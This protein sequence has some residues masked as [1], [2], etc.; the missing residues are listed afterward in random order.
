QCFGGHAGVTKNEMLQALERNAAAADAAPDWP[1]A[2]WQALRDGG[3]LAWNIPEAFGGQGRHGRD[4][5]DAYQ[6]LA[7][8]CLTTCFILSQRDGAVRRICDHGSE[9]LR[10]ELLP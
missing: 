3:A 2:S 10:Q 9:A 1:T 6:E 7:A 4:L 8:A 5:L